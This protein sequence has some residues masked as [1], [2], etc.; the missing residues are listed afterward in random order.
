MLI[1][2]LEPILKY[3]PF[4]QSVDYFYPLV[5]DGFL[6]G[7]I[8]FANVVS[9]VYATGVVNIDLLKIIISVPEEFTDEERDT[10]LPEIIEGFKD[11]AKEV[12]CPLAM[13]SISINPACIIGGIATS[14]VPKN[15]IIL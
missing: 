4:L 5:D 2:A 1:N 13:S 10:V 12:K 7:K 14:V 15:E 9:D 6:M 8:A 11:S 3:I